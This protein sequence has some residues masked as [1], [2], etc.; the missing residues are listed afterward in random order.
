MGF[1]DAI[2]LLYLHLKLY[3]NRAWRRI[4]QVIIDEA[5]DYTP[6]QFE[7]FHQLF[8]NA[9]LTI[10]GDINQRLTQS[11][12]AA[13]YDH[14][15]AIFDKENS[16]RYTL[17]KSFRCSSEILAFA[18]NFLDEAP[19]V[20]AF[21]RHG[22]TLC[23]VRLSVITALGFPVSCR[24][25]TAVARKIMAASALITKTES[26]A[27]SLY[28]E[29]KTRTNVHQLRLQNEDLQGT[30][31]VPVALTKGLEF[32]AVILADADANTYHDDADRN[33]L[34]ITATRALH[35]LSIFCEGTLS[36]LIPVH[37][38][39]SLCYTDEKQKKEDSPCT[40]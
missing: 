40:N 7:I 37:S 12:D 4:R 25:S 38:Q 23:A 24:R 15:A 30:L 28:S 14:I 21:N 22:E 29:L 27:Q 13:L 36:P 33:L 6:L 32:D 5:Q 10:L 31:I 3:G 16:L 35:R 1:D 20:E 2:C 26:V 17:T 9:K 39:A 18:L 8:P 11:A 34:Y 19:Q